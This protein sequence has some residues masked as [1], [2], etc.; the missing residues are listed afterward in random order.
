MDSTWI[1][2]IP[3]MLFAFYA[4]AKVSSAYRKYSAVGNRQGISGTRAARQI[5]DNNGLSSVPIEIVAGKLTDHYDPRTRIMRL[6]PEVHN[7]TSIAAVSIAA[8]EAGHAIQHATS[9]A[10]LKI[11]NAI[12]PVVSIASN[13]AWPLLLI[14]LATGYLGLFDLGIV[15]FASAL[16]FQAITL[17]VE[18]DASK[19]AITQLQ[20]LAIIQDEEAGSAKK[21]LSAAAMTYVAAMAVSLANLLR[22]LML[23]N[24]S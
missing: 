5:L 20:A 23:R 14:G 9:Y 13:L 19:R 1:I 7:G 17:P 21:V 6:S 11:R 4:Q 22:L 2:L 24:R 12:A 8:H 18:F 10:P 3:A 16:L 15:L